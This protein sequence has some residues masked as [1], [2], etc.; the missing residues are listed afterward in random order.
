[1]S[2]AT[3]RDHSDRHLGRSQAPHSKFMLDLKRRQSTGRREGPAPES[4][5]T[6]L[7]SGQ[8]PGPG[9]QSPLDG[10]SFTPAEMKRQSHVILETNVSKSS[11]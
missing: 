3:C 2:Q 4:L 5:G 1:M 8:E 6:R 9:A 11:G 10:I 7:F